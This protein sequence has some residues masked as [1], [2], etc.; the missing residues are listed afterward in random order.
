MSTILMTPLS[1]GPLTLRNRVVMAP[2][3]RMR[4]RMP[5]NIPGELNAR[6]YAQRASAGLIISEATPISP[7]GHGYYGTPGIHT[8]EQ[9]DGWKLVTRAV[10]EQAAPMFLQLWHVGRVSHNDLLPG[11]ARPVAPS[12]LS[13][14]GEAPTA[15]GPKPHPVARALETSEIPGIV[16]D[17]RIA[18]ERAM[19]AGFDGVEVHSANG[20]LLEQ[21]LSDRA[22]LRTDQYGG[23]VESRARF[24]MEVVEAVIGIWGPGRVGVRISPSNKANNIDFADRWGTFSYVFQQLDHFPLAYVHMVEPRVND[25]VDAVSQFDL[26]SS[27][28]RKL[29]TGD[30]RLIS[31]GGHNRDTAIQT[32]TNG[33]ADFVAFGRSFIAN[34]DLPERLEEDAPLSPY[35]RSTF[36]GGS[37]KGYIDYPTLK[38]LP[39]A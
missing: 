9:V 20:Y 28:F 1:M 15:N 6:Y 32:L 26:P 12:A 11:G 7:M 27:R 39:I 4:A 25:N 24:L 5:G 21:F 16:E 10:H 30:I 31:A 35:D 36:Y 13:A 3:T 8:D 23:A 34:P 17:Y 29:L 2:L 18:A 14:G 22:N 33:D 19:D 37:E 38:E